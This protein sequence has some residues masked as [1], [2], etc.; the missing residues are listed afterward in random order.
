V[1]VD[2]QTEIEIGRPCAEVSAYASDADN[3]TAWYENIDS[4]VWETEPP[5]SVGSRAAFVARFLGRTL[6]YTYEIRELVSGEHLMMSTADGPFPM[7]TS[8]TWQDEPGGGTRMSL[9]NRGEP[10]GFAKVGAFVMEAAMRR[11]NAKDLNA[12]KAIL[13]GRRG[14]A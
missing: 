4:V 13:E 7:E 9:R 11:A 2:V 3:A 5:V 12:L 10:S 1:S 14:A 8:Y 6:S